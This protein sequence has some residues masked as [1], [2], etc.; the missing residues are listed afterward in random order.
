MGILYITIFVFITI[1]TSFSLSQVY[2]E[3]IIYDDDYIVEKF[4]TGLDY[5]TTMIFVGE[6]ILVLEKDT[7]K[8]IL[9][10]DNG[11]IYR[12]HALDVPISSSGEAGLLG[13]ASTFNHVY[14]YFTES[15][16][17]FDRSVNE[18]PLGKTNVI[19]QYDWNGKKL[20]NPILI[21]EL[22]VLNA[23]H[24][25]GIIAVGLNNEI[26]FIIGD[27]WQYT[28]SSGDAITY[29]MSNAFQWFKIPAVFSIV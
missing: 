3:P 17:D 25:G 8:V 5:P 9:I 19:Y 2:A 13:I 28:T 27:Q 23:S 7:G 26:Y 6:D 22:P 20:T 21:K 29:D 24:L 10:Q 14:L 4:V 18:S 11:I 12:E 1:I 16:S 15:I